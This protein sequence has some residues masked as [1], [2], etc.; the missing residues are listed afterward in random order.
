MNDASAVY[1][2]PDG[3]GQALVFP[4]Y[5]VQETQGD[6]FNTLISIR[7]Q[8]SDSKV[9]KLR[10]R[11]ARNGREVL[12]FDVYLAPNDM[13]TGAVVPASSDPAAPAHVISADDSCTD[14]R[15]DAVASSGYSGVDFRNDAYAAADA[16]DGAGVGLDRTREGFF[17]LIEMG[18]VGGA[19]AAAI[20]LSTT[21]SYAH[22]DCSAVQ[23]IRAPTGLGP[24]SGGLSGTMTLINVRTG[25][26]FG[27]NAE[28]LD[29]LA[30][31]PM[32]HPRSEPPALDFN[33]PGI[34]P[35]SHVMAN[36]AY[37]RSVWSRPV[38]AVSAALM[39][40]S[41]M[42]EFVAD[43]GSRSRTSMVL[44]FPTKHHYVTTTG[45]GAP[46]TSAFNA[47]CPPGSGEPVYQAIFS[48][49]SRDVLE[50]FH[51]SCAYYASFGYP[52]PDICNH[53]PTICAAAAVASISRPSDTVTA[54]GSK[55]IAF[56][57]LWFQTTSQG[58]GYENGSVTF[59]S[60]SSIVLTSL[61]SST[62]TDMRTG[63]VTTGPHSYRGLPIVGFWLRTFENA[64][65]PCNGNSAVCQGNYGSAFPLAYK[66]TITQ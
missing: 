4:Y 63:A 8:T 22:V 40:S 43:A 10:F 24:P 44:T 59:N 65:V 60:G 50:Q 57:G 31:V 20:A 37:Y 28:A 33:S 54:L 34:E 42:G 7:N 23:G 48:R 5:T 47:Q 46:F 36:G 6:F 2:N 41:W 38:D 35:V 21:N 53:P 17:E 3:H 32:Y 64:S 58:Y 26:D 25:M 16:N 56:G 11:E 19:T 1:L 39:R 9:A 52:A 29:D 62:R 18:T 27:L 15:I 61:D 66:R 51:D 55:T 49:E 45:A 13:W 14:P 30:R 12:A